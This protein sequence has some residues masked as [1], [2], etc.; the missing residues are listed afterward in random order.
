MELTPRFTTYKFNIGHQYRAL[1]SVKELLMAADEITVHL[2]FS[3]N[4]T[5]RYGEEIQTVHFGGSHTKHQYKQESATR[6]KE[7]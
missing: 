7:L 2:E 5:C 4:Y 3:E 1:R 6:P